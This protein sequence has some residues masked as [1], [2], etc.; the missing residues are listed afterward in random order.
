MNPT[1]LALFL[2]AALSMLTTLRLTAADYPLLR[3]SAMIS[4]VGHCLAALFVLTKVM[5]LTLPMLNLV[6]DLAMV[7]IS[8][9][10]VT[11]ALGLILERHYHK[12]SLH[13]AHH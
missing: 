12:G 6:V 2:L 7:L 11:H 10:A 9:G 8:V 5:S 4:M 1:L 3:A 13:D